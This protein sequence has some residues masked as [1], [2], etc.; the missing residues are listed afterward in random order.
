MVSK[1]YTEATIRRLL[2][3]VLL[4]VKGSDPL[5]KPY[6]RVLAAGEKGRKLL[7][8][9]KKEKDLS[10]PIITNINKDGQ[11]ALEA[12]KMLEYDCLASVFTI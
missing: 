7:R 9:L 10:I 2:L 4:G 11:A 8:H 3:Y 12:G 5:G 1:R 6:T